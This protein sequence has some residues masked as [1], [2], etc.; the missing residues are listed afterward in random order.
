[1]REGILSPVELIDIVAEDNKYLPLT[2]T[3]DFSALRWLLLI[4]TCGTL[5]QDLF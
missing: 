2:L 1:M 3:S 4:N 5:P